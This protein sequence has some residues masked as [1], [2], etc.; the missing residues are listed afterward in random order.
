MHVAARLRLRLRPR[1]A[2]R[3]R[4]RAQRGRA[5]YTGVWTLSRLSCSARVMKQGAFAELSL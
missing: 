4:L 2:A 5:D 1:L 3:S